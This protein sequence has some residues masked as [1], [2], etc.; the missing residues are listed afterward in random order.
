MQQYAF[1]QDQGHP[2]S[3]CTAYNDPLGI[4]GPVVMRESG[5][6]GSDAEPEGGA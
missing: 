1:L 2:L 4:F 6:V 3:Q 5:V